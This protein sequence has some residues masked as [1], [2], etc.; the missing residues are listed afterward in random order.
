MGYLKKLVS[1][2][3]FH[4]ILSSVFCLVF[5]HSLTLAHQKVVVIPLFSCDCNTSIDSDCDGKIIAN[6]LFNPLDYF[7]RK[8]HSAV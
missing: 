5:L 2:E 4:L 6:L 1:T 7:K 8:P 3:R